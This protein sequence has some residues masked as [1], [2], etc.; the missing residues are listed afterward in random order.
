MG[1]FCWGQKPSAEAEARMTEEASNEK[2]KLLVQ[3]WAIIEVWSKVLSP[4]HYPD[5]PAN[6]KPVMLPF[7][8]WP[9]DDSHLFFNQ[10]VKMFKADCQAEAAKWPLQDFCAA[11]MNL[12]KEIQ[13]DLEAEEAEREEARKKKNR[14]FFGR[15]LRCSFGD[16]SKGTRRERRGS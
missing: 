15:M 5:L 7:Y 4:L 9:D 2:C 16:A 3:T 12:I 6:M 1:S 14:G 13:E 10:L 8:L 11:T